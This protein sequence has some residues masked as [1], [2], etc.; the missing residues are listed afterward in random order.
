MADR[1]RRT[2]LRGDLSLREE[3]EF[4][5]PYGYR[6]MHMQ[7][8]WGRTVMAFRRVRRDSPVV[9]ECIWIL[10]IIAIFLGIDIGYLSHTHQV[11][12]QGIEVVYKRQMTEMETRYK[13]QIKDLESLTIDHKSKF[14]DTHKEHANEMRKKQ[15]D[16][17]EDMVNN[18]NGKLKELV[19]AADVHW[20][21]HDK[22]HNDIHG[23][24][25]TEE[26]KVK[27]GGRAVVN[28]L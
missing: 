25:I 20:D 9:I 24:D 22:F 13:K 15:K 3:D 19:S 2:R 11:D 21:D 27:A 8:R 16:Y 18:L 10:V 23:T 12:M 7:S 14:I 28:S 1:H 4:D 17:L 26:P 5:S 6:P